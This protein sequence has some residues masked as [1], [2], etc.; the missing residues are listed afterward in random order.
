[1]AKKSSVPE[2]LREINTD[3]LAGDKATPWDFRMD[4]ELKG[5]LVSVERKPIKGFD[6]GPPKTKCVARVEVTNVATGEPEVYAAFLPENYQRILGAR[7]MT[8]KTVAIVRE[9]EGFDT[10]YRI[11]A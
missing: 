4:P 8:G 9:G 2:G 3:G 6:G 10:R 11:F 5:T 1:M 7:G